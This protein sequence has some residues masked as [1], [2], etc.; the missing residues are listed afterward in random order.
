MTKF[1]TVLV[2]TII[3]SECQHKQVD[4]W[5]SKVKAVGRML[6]SLYTHLLA[7]LSGQTCV[8]KATLGTHGYVF[9]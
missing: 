3:G 2:S 4:L 8:V 7:V 5:I 6:F 1:S 9:I